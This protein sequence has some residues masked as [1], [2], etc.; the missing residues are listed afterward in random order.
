MKL[1]YKVDCLVLPLYS[2]DSYETVARVVLVY[3]H[4]TKYPAD[5]GI[6]APF[7]KGFLVSLPQ[8]GGGGKGFSVRFLHFSVVLLLIFIIYTY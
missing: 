3:A 1:R 8:R 2:I 7:L 6:K 5:H 4:G